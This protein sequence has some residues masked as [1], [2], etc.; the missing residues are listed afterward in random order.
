MSGPTRTGI[1]G[2]TFDPIHQGHLDAAHV[3]RRVLQLHEVLLIPAR[4]AP[5]RAV[6]PPRASAYHRFAM[7]ALATAGQETLPICDVELRSADPSYTSL[8]LQQLALAGY[9][10]A[11]LFF[12]TGADAFAE[13]ATWYD[14]PAV[15]DHGHFAVVSRPGYPVN[16]LQSRLPDLAS[17]MRNVSDAIA[18][19][20][21]IE[22]CTAKFS[23]WLI[24]A[25]TS[26]A[27]SSD[28]RRRLAAGKPLAGLTPPDVETYIRRHR[29]YLPSR[30]AADQLHEH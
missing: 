18:S 29:L 5:H 21:H 2:G 12:I 25:P 30:P 14:F 6:L 24:D 15:L 26:D 22:G 8:T 19:K 17:R 10:P 4:V 20:V 1:L 23:I 13:I 28:I 11:Q 16:Q 9:D 27:S 7:L 3:V